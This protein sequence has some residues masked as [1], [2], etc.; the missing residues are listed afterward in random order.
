MATAGGHI[1]L[2]LDSDYVF[3]S[4]HVEGGPNIGPLSTRRHAGKSFQHQSSDSYNH[5]GLC[6]AHLLA[7][8]VTHVVGG[9]LFAPPP[10]A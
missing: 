6:A 7:S 8:A 2:F 9:V 4:V 5:L 3:Q 10:P 1:Q